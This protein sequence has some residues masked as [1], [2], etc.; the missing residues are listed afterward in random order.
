MLRV[1][2]CPQQD[3]RQMLKTVISVATWAS[4]ELPYLAFD[5]EI[6]KVSLH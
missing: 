4:S 3:N 6:A 5:L 2:L 1:H